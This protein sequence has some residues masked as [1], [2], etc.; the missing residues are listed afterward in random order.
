MLKK[1]NLISINSK[2]FKDK[3]K[4]STLIAKSNLIKNKIQGNC[5]IVSKKENDSEYRHEMLILKD[6]EHAKLLVN[7]G[8]RV[9][10]ELGEI[11][12]EKEKGYYLEIEE[13]TDNIKKQLRKELKEINIEIKRLE[14]LIKCK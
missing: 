14:K 5:I 13:I 4:L 11:V 12:I 3:M 2:V 6:I 7:G 8:G 9:F 10:S 1:F